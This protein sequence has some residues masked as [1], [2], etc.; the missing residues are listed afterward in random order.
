MKTLFVAFADAA[1]PFDAAEY[2]D[3]FAECPPFFEDAFGII[4]VAYKIGILWRKS[5]IELNL[6]LSIG[7]IMSRKMIDLFCE[8]S[9]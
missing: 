3:D 4:A 7:R 2:G 1:D 9:S 8:T 6:E 5:Q